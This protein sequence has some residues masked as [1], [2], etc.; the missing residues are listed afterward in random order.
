MSTK[1]I[2]QLI[3]GAVLVVVGLPIL[4]AGAA[5]G[6]L[7]L[8]VQEDDGWF[9]ATPETVTSSAVA[10]TSPDIDLGSRPDGEDWVP[11]DGDLAAVRLTA[12]GENLFVGIA[13]TADVDSYLRGVAHDAVADGLFEPGPVELVTSPGAPRVAPPATQTFWI[14]S[15]DSSV[16]WDVEP[17]TWTA[18]VMRA[19]GTA[20]V[21]ATI[22][23]EVQLSWLGPLAVAT[24]VGGIVLLAAGFGLVV[25]AASSTNLPTSTRGGAPFQGRYPL[26]LEARLDEPLSRWQ[27]LVKWFLAIPHVLVLVPLW[28]GLLVTT[29]IA[30]F[31]ILV[32][33]RYPRSL[34]AY[35]V[36][37]LRWTWRVGFYA[38]SAVGT[39]RYPPFSLASDPAYPADLDVVAPE[40]LSRGLV[41]VKSWLLALPHLLVVAVLTGGLGVHVGG[42]TT[43]LVLVAAVVLLVSG[44]YPLALFDV[45]IGCNRWAYR[46]LAYVMLMTDE[47]P[48]FRFDA[49]GP[50]PRSGDEPPAPWPPPVGQVEGPTGR[51]SDLVDAAR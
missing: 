37:V 18:V 13:P 14:A 1:R 16:L 27:W 12:R 43:A 49:G 26:R 33:G 30:F 3:V 36:G 10:I 9:R 32:T 20:G 25:T 11:F 6:W 51:S 21:D 28:I 45:I 47:Y 17:G 7:R 5:L 39:D 31:A 46:V 4:V 22:G 35:G 34:F 42:A 38:F 8:A 19:D 23:A 50:E 48:P 24:A 15:G 41:L 40:R 44:T 2:I 29:T